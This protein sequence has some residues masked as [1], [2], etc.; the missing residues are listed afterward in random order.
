M[1]EEK[2]RII[3]LD[4]DSRLLKAISDELRF[5]ILQ[6]GYRFDIA[7]DLN[8]LN[9]LLK[10]PGEI[11]IGVVDLWITDTQ[12]N[13][14][15]EEGGQKALASIREAWPDSYIFVLSSHLDSDAL[16]S[17]HDVERIAIIKKPVPT[18]VLIDL[19]REKMDE[20]TQR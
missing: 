18:R 2:K 3:L 8:K 4:D 9:D 13:I 14:Q 5:E 6:L 12:T 7:Q 20:V 1:D 19:I 16:E 17:L 10:K 15:D 11:L